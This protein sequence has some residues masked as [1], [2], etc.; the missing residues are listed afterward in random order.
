MLTKGAT[1][2][3][4]AR[5]EDG[6]GPDQEPVRSRL[7]DTAT[8]LFASQGFERTSVQ[9]I[10]SSAG[11]TKGALYHYFASKDDLLWESYA[12]L[13]RQ[14]TEHLAVIGA[15]E[16]TATERLRAAA[17]DVV[18]TTL[19]NMDD[20]AVFARNL[21]LLGPDTREVVRAG[22][23]EYRDAFEE[24][25]HQGV[26]QGEFRKDLHLPLLAYNFFGSIMYLTVWYSPDGPWS[27][28]DIATGFGD[29]LIATLT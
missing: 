25:I 5:R 8:H 16:G 1:M 3:A 23:R 13:L 9:E 24:L 6:A 28:E 20:A 19:N 21:H 2:T 14:Q 22:R 11:V 12:R 7:L 26:E 18:A 4:R 29:Q 15:R 27:V 10:V 17:I